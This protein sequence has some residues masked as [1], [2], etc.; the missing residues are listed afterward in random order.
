MAA[1]VR[2]AVAVTSLSARGWVEEDVESVRYDTE[3]TRIVVRM[4]TPP[5]HPVV[6]LVV[7]GTGATPV[8]GADPVAPLAGVDGGPPGGRH[9]GHDAV[10]TVT[11]AMPARE[12]S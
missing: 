4:A 1:S 11:G 12:G 5:Q 6:R 10:I 7:K 9:D 8:Y 2:R 3:N